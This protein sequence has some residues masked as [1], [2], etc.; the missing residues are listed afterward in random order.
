MIFPAP[1]RPFALVALIG[2]LLAGCAST[3]ELTSPE[4]RNDLSLVFGYVD[5]S[6]APS[7]L[8]FVWMKR[9]R[10]VEDKPYYS[11]WTVDGMFFRAN[12]PPGT[13]KF[14]K[15]G[16]HS[17][18]KNTTYNYRFPEQGKT[19]LDRQIAKPGIYYVGSY[20][21]KEIK[22]SFWKPDNWDLERV[23]SPS[24]RELLEKMLPYAKHE[25]WKKL[26]QNRIAEL[27]K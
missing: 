17:G 8:D 9:M 13:Y 6:D 25:H 24:E 11:F 15:F 16:G 19:E 1:S 27:K 21:Y 23:N 26:I 20:R 3:P 2:L 12:V 10:P 5:M 14:D 22:T 4:G 18:W 7:K